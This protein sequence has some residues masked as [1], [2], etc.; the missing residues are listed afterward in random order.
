MGAAAGAG[1]RPRDL[2]DPNLARD[3]LFAPVG[4]PGQ[5]LRGG[6]EH[7]HRHVLPDDLVCLQLGL[8]ELVGGQG[9]AG[10]HPHRLGSDVKAHVLSP[11]EPV[12]RPRED[13]LAG[14][15]LH[16]VEPPGPVDPG[17]HRRP[18]P[19]RLGQRVHRVP[20]DAV[21]FVDVR[22]GQG[23]A[24]LQSQGAP[25]RRL[26]APLGVKDGSVQ[27]QPP[28]APFQRLGRR[29]VGGTFGAVGVVFVVFLGA[30]HP[31][32]PPVG[33]NH[34][35]VYHDFCL[36]K[37]GAGYVMIRIIRARSA[38]RPQIL[39]QSEGTVYA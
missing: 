19:G 24:A 28:A 33:S 27:C 1:I 7:P 39:V 13:V 23:L 4:H 9:D 35:T 36:W 25:V 32:G 16:L 29:D 31:L 6:V 34:D 22:H 14:V 10:V 15:L 37:I 20:D 38:P 8:A 26:A 3:L 11:E 17:R 2:H 5:F 12:Q 18:R 21:L 30:L